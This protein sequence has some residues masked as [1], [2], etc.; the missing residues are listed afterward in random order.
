MP[1]LNMNIAVTHEEIQTHMQELL[2]QVNLRILVTGNMY[3]DVGEQLL[4]SVDGLPN[5]CQ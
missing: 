4:V 2:S 5:I 3:K 1:G